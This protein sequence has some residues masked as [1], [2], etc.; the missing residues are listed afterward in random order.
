MTLLLLV[1]VT[2]VII[3][4]MCSLFEATLYSTRLATLEAERARGKHKSLAQRFL[5]MKADIAKPTAAILILNT[6]ANTAGATICGMYATTVL[7]ASW[8]PLFSVL[9]TLT[10]LCIGEI[11]PKTFGATKWKSIWPF[12]VWPLALMEK[13]FAPLIYVSRGFARFFRADGAGP[14]I[15]EVEIQAMIQVGGKSGELTPAELQLL[16]AVFHFDEL[17]V[18]QI[19]VS[20]R[21]VVVFERGNTL[22]QCIEIA[23]RTKHTRYPVCQT[24]LDD[25]IGLVHI[26]DLL[27][28]PRD[29]E[30]KLES[31]V[32]P[33]KTVPETMPISRLLRQMQSTH[34]HMASVIDEFGTAVGIV[35]LENVLEQI[36]GAVQDEFDTEM[37]EIVP[38]GEGQ[39]MVLGQLPIERLNREL[40]LDLDDTEVDTISGLLVSRLGRLLRVGDVVQLKGAEAEVLEVQAGRATSIRL[41]PYNAQQDGDEESLEE[42]DETSS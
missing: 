16:S 17:V 28:V 1:A 33:M 40:K 19:M 4:G 37:P 2:T 6:T 30:F 29:E 11:L 18:R 21:S 10:I 31:I 35:T 14:E 24:S 26:K 27:G 13:I 25:A 32:R 23:Q 42:G 39:F 15:T 8:V 22:A 12:I 41:T 3:S 38:E 36:V 34:Q 7:G 5:R 20:R 9:L